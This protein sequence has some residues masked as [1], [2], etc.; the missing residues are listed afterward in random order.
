MGIAKRLQYARKVGLAH[1]SEETASLYPSSAFYSSM[2]VLGMQD[3]NFLSV[4]ARV[5]SKPEDPPP[6]LPQ[7]PKNMAFGGG[8]APGG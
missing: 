4:H 8:E 6:G 3:V 5:V 7:I 2:E 1:F